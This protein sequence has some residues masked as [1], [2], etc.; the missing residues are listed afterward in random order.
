[1]TIDDNNC[2]LAVLDTDCNVDACSNV[3]QFWT[4]DREGFL[5]AYSV[6]SRKSFEQSE[7]LIEMLQRESTAGAP[8][9]VVG[10]K[11][12]LEKQRQ[13]ATFEGKNLALGWGG[14]SRDICRDWRQR[15]RGVSR[16]GARDSSQAKRGTQE[17]GSRLCCLLSELNVRTSSRATCCFVSVGRGTRR[18]QDSWCGW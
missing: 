16:F 14:I 11:C 18:W 17:H 1:M 9:V 6:T 13:V 12:D 7:R 10:T 8:M 4:R 15:G 5:I 2:I 3:F